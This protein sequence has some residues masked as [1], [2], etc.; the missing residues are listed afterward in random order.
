MTKVGDKVT[1]FKVGDNAGVGCMVGSCGTCENC[2]NDLEN[3]CPK[4][5]WTYNQFHVDGSRTFGGYSDNIVVDNHFAVKFPMG[6]PLESA[7]PL[8][9]AGITVY[10][11]INYFGLA[12]LGKTLGVVGLG[13]L[14]HMAVKFSKALGAKVTVIS[15][16]PSKK[17]EA[18]E[19]LGADEFLISHDQEQMQVNQ[20]LVN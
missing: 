16:S 20:M 10:S 14:G 1:K 8:M 15:T 19:R 4:M 12:G 5:I 13:G 17:I 2:K 11:P 3:Y 18:L 9:C 7:G 6:F